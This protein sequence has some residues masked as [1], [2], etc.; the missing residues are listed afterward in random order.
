MQQRTRRTAAEKAE[1]L[2]LVAEVG[3][4]ETARL[5]G[6]PHGTIASWAKRSGVTSPEP[7]LIMKAALANQASWAT[8]KVELAHRLTD[9]LERLRQ[10]LFAPTVERKVVVVSD[11]ATLGSHAEIVDVERDAPTHADQKAI[12]TT[13]AIGVDKVLLMLGE[14]TERI[15]TLP[16]QRTPEIEQEL[17]KVIELRSA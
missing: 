12:M 7:G 5:T 17:A 8:R 9:D 13:L 2:R 11:G 14:A 10:Q 1:A 15:E 4:S 6:I 16:P 3:Q